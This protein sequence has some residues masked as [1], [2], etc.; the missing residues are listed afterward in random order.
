MKHSIR[1]Q[2]LNLLRQGLTP[3]ELALSIAAGSAVGVFPILGTTTILSVLLAVRFRLNIPVMQLTNQLVF[4]LQLALFIPFMRLGE[5]IYGAEALRLSPREVRQVFL[6]SPLQGT[7]SLAQSVAHAVTGW[8]L[9]VPPTVY[10]VYRI[11]NSVFSALAE[12]NR[13]VERLAA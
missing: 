8:A 9:V 3:K 11:L 7:T 13:N 4:S 6:H 10:V 5:W 1:A 12:R 2:V